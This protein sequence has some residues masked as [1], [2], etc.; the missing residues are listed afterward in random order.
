MDKSIQSQYVFQ[1]W[2]SHALI[3][4]LYKYNLQNP[5]GSIKDFFNSINENSGYNKISMDNIRNIYTLISLG[6][7]LLC[8]PKEAKLL[9]DIKKFK[10]TEDLIDKFNPCICQEI[11]TN[12]SISVKSC[13]E[14]RI[15]NESIPEEELVSRSNMYFLGILRNSLS[16]ANFNIL[17]DDTIQFN[18]YIKKNKIKRICNIKINTYTY[19]SLLMYL[20]DVIYDFKDL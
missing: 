14:Y 17:C 1:T 4:K 3:E 11:E 10:I 20:S 5:D 13:Q 16:H 2:L 18:G 9:G 15:F 19:H 12:E 6:Y 8:Y 7:S